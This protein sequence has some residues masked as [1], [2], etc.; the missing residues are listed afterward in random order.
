MADVRARPDSCWD[1]DGQPLI[2]IS[3]H[4]RL[5]VI[6]QVHVADWLADLENILL[7]A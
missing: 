2:P 3:Q 7:Y 1:R 6:R 5:Q 4:V